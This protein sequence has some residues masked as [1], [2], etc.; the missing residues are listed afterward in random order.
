MKIVVNGD[1]GCG[2]S[3]A[4]RKAMQQLGWTQPGGF[5][6]HWGGAGRGASKLYLSTWS[7]ETQVVARR[8]AKSD[9]ARDLP[10]EVDLALFNRVAVASLAAS[11]G[12]VVVD[13]LGVLELGAADLVAAL[14]TV[15]RGPRPILAVIQRR[16]LERWLQIVGLENV[17]QLIAVDPATRDEL[18]GKIVSL[19]HA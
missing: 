5:F 4:V 2:K 13:E 12:P 15:F 7:G 16:A 9:P 6:T 17:T 11:A 18:P 10:F 8:V 14:A 19:F 3:T 1:I